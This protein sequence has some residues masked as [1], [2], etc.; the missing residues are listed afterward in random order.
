MIHIVGL[1]ILILR[2]KLNL[3]LNKMALSQAY[4]D[5]ISYRTEFFEYL[6]EVFNIP[7]LSCPSKQPN[8]KYCYFM[9]TDLQ[10][11]DI[12]YELDSLSKSTDQAQILLDPNTFLKM[13]R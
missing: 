7:K 1:K 13:E 11:Q 3:F 12:Y 4:L 10:K 9:N 6:K 2:E 8:G 5:H